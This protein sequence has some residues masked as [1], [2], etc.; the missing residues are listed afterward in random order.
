MKAISFSLEQTWKLNCGYAVLFPSGRPGFCVCVTRAK[1]N[2]ESGCMVW[3]GFENMC[4]GMTWIAKSRQ[5][6]CTNRICPLQGDQCFPSLIFLP[7]KGRIMHMVRLYSQI[8]PISF[9]KQHRKGTLLNRKLEVITVEPYQICTSTNIKQ[10]HKKVFSAWC[11]GC[12]GQ[13]RFCWRAASKEMVEMPRI[14]LRCVAYVCVIP[15]IF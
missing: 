4:L 15:Q 8:H 14:N 10:K 3:A 12:V 9:P 11:K 2:L 5:T 7:G 6:F 1:L 13:H